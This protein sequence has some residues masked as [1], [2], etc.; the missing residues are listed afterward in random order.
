MPF[1]TAV[2]TRRYIVGGRGKGEPDTGTNHEG[3]LLV[4]DLAKEKA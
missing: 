1:L 4:R 2:R 3:S